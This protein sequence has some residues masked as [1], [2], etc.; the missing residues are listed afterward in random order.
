[1]GS[2]SIDQFDVQST[3]FAS[4]K[5]I[6]FFSPEAAIPVALERAAGMSGMTLAH[7]SLACLLG[8]A[9]IPLSDYVWCVIPDDIGYDALDAI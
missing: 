9:E 7:H 2:D 4:Q 8:E 5:R 3:S 1:M 6:A